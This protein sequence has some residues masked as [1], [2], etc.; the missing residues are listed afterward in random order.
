MM[1]EPR[2]NR[3]LSVV[4]Y[5]PDREFRRCVARFDGDVRPAN[6]AKLPVPAYENRSGRRRQGEVLYNGDTAMR[7][8]ALQ[9]GD[10]GEPHGDV[11][12]EEA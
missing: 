7:I 3:L 1:G 6:G 12:H 5:L 8:L 2:P 10:C 11:H 4:G 9:A